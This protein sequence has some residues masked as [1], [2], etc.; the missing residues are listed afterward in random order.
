MYL[1]L[2]CKVPG[3]TAWDELCQTPVIELPTHGIDAARRKLQNT[4]DRYKGLGILHPEAE[5]RI[6]RVGEPTDDAETPIASAIMTLA[7]LALVGGAFAVW[8]GVA[9]HLI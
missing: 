3:D 5:Y 8:A 4:R 6:I 1:V 9:A 2:Q 7:A